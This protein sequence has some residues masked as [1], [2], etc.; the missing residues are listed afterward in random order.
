MLQIITIICVTHMQINFQIR[1]SIKAVIDKISN[2]N[3]IAPNSTY[4][5][6]SQL[7]KYIC[8]FLDQL[9]ASSLLISW[10]GHVRNTLFHFCQLPPVKKGW[11]VD[12]VDISSV[13]Q[14]IWQQLTTISLVYHLSILR[15]FQFNEESQGWRWLRI[16]VLRIRYRVKL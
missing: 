8:N 6:K 13:W 5:H 1:V 15:Y 4:S 2:F 11:N 3:E 7:L 12:L 9:I 10:Q 16:R 14:F